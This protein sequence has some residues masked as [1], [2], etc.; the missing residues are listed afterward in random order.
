M[1]PLS[2]IKAA[3]EYV[4]TKEPLYYALVYELTIRKAKEVPTMGTDGDF[5]YYN[6]DFVDSLPEDELRGVILHEVF[7]CVFLHMWRREK[8]DPLRWNIAAD[9]AI[10]PMVVESFPIP[11]G[12]LIDSKYY[13]MSAEKIYEQLPKPPKSKKENKDQNE[14]GDKGDKQQ[15]GDS[16]SGDLKEQEW[17]DHSK[18]SCNQED[19]EKNKK[20]ESIIDKL[21]GRKE[22]EKKESAK[23]KNRQK[24]LEKKWKKLFEKNILKNYGK[25][26]ESMKRLIEKKYYIPTI[27][28]ASLVSNIL[29]EDENDYTFSSPDRRFLDAS[30]ILPGLYS[31]DRLKDVVFAYDTSGSITEQQLTQF[32]VETMNLFNN[33]SSLQG[34]VAV[35]DAYLHVFKKISPQQGVDDFGFIGGGGTDFNPVFDEV[36]KKGIK[37][38]ALFYF[39]DTYG[40]F[41][42]KEPDYPV[43][44]LVQTSIGVE[45]DVFVPF[46]Q[47]IP[48]LIKV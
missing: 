18:W 38:K 37:P 2:K 23:E 46:G 4:C 29:S 19:K 25:L 34:W 47:V 33:F 40:E 3:M 9:Y 45:P 44:W 20:K 28:W 7:H 27:D 36:E 5:L 1:S 42:I 16:S 8:R 11:E 17:G 12:G 35:C 21:T 30:F 6:P 39:T 48:F 26:P 31:V 43:F 22:R 10:N 24:K 32:Y 14:N 41:P 13:G 15:G